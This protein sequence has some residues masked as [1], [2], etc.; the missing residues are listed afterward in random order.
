MFDTELERR[1]RMPDAPT[2]NEKLLDRTLQ[3]IVDDPASWNQGDWCLV[4]LSKVPA[5]VV[6]G[7]VALCGT[8]ACLAGHALLQSGQYQL[9]YVGISHQGDSVVHAGVQFYD[10]QGHS[11]YDGGSIETTAG[12]LLGLTK[13]EASYLFST[14]GGSPVEFCAMVRAYLGLPPKTYTPSPM[15][16]ASA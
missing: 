13:G 7:D 15:A 1:V 9:Q 16:K 10:L 14:A 12:D 5:A 2:L 3:Q 11:V 4:R 8:T 6:T